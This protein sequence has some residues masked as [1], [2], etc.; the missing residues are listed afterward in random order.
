M[1]KKSFFEKFGLVESVAASE[2]E[3]P[4]V[5]RIDYSGQ[6]ECPTI[7]GDLAVAG[8]CSGRSP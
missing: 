7:Q 5:T 1:A 2:Y 8:A 6:V 4:S 3:M